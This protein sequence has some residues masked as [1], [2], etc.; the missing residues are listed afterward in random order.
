MVNVGDL[1]TW[2]LRWKNGRELARASRSGL[3]VSFDYDV[4]GLRTEKTVSATNRHEYLY[5]GGQLLQDKYTKGSFIYC[6]DF[7]YDASG[8]PYA[9]Y[10]TCDGSSTVYYYLLN[11]QGDVVR[12]V[13][14][15]GATVAN[16]KYDPYGKLLSVTDANGIAITG[17]T[18]IAN[19]N[20]LRYRGYYYD[21]ETGWYYLQSRYYD[22]IIKRFLNADT[23]AST[24][25]G[26]L[27]YN[28]F[29][30]CGNNPVNASD[31]SG[32]KSIIEHD[33]GGGVVGYTDTGSG[34]S[35]ATYHNNGVTL[36][37]SGSDYT[38]TANIYYSG[39]LS[40]STLNAGI[41]KNWD[42]SYTVNGQEITL[43]VNMVSA[44]YLDTDAIKVYTSEGAAHSNSS[45]SW[46]VGGCSRVN[47]YQYDEYGGKVDTGWLLAHEFG[48]CLGIEDYY[49]H[50]DEAGF[51][52]SKDFLS[53]M[54]VF[55]M[56]ASS[57]DVAM[58]IAAFT[59]GEYQWWK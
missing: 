29:A 33:F 40:S 34:S 24:G 35:T 17:A 11:L 19:L 26:F 58:A 3:A 56:H 27:G 7:I 28:M 43:T 53:I 48:H 45:L 59:T 32:S 37:V 52:Y 39:P 13:D 38:I 57:A 23:Y 54:N 15:T 44:T 8:R 22:P 50:K 1:S 18:H 55:G 41:K 47:I 51:G 14:A 46:F 6:L 36:T 30:Y 9:L 16:Y 21:T 49:T 25:Q 5:A 42:G 12:L 4:D 20:P 2:T 31:P 10:Y